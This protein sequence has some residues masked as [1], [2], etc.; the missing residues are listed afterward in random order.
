MRV[1]TLLAA[2]MCLTTWVVASNAAPSETSPVEKQLIEYVDTHNGDALELLEAVVNMNS[3]TMNFDGVHRVGEVFMSELTE[4]GFDTQWLDGD[5]FERAG[6]LV[7][8]RQGQ[9]PH[10]LLIG[11]LDT[12]FEPDSPFQRFERVSEHIARGPGIVDMKGGDVIIIQVMKAFNAIGVLDGMTITVI[13]TGDEERPGRHVK[14]SR[15][16]LIDCARQAD[17]AVA[18]ENGDNDPTTAVITRRGSTSWRL[19]VRGKPAHSSLVFREDIGA[20]AIYEASRILSGFYER[21][22]GERHL[23][24]NPGVILGGTTVDFDTTLSRGSAF[25][26]SNVIAEHA[27]VSGDLRTVSMEQLESA[28]SRMRA[29]VGKHLPHTTA[30]IRFH[31]NYPPMAPTDGNKKLLSILDRV[32]RDLGF[33]P[34]TP[35]DPSKAGAADVSFTAQHV[36]MAID[37][38][39]L[40][41]DG[42]HTVDELADLRTLPMQTKRAAVL[43]YRLSTRQTGQ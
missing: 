29:V 22:A 43:L 7:A 42:D 14:R 2:I 21:M 35:V 38:I 23:A 15:E 26:K 5:S 28:K 10:L 13:M 37:G 19:T 30:E 33:G 9:G 4:L 1:P 25:G 8:R 41:G 34:I 16:A 39:G 18:F 11:H 12:V 24:F 32:S 36:D 27:V 31:D 17:I 40:V 20:G 3:G 6:H